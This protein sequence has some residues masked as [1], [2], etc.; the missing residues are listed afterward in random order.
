MSAFYR[1]NTHSGVLL[2]DKPS[3]LSSNQA[4]V[5]AKRALGI[6]KAGHTGSLDPLASGL[7]PLCFGEATKFVAS[8]LLEAD[9]GYHVVAK[10]GETTTTGDSEGDIVQ[11]LPVPL[12]NTADVNTAL[13]RFKGEIEQI[14]PMYSA[15]KHKGQPLYKLARAG[16]EIERAARRIHIYRLELEGIKQNEHQTTVSMIVECSKG[17]Y[18]RSLVEDLGNALGC[19]AHV[20]ALRRLWVG[21]FQQ[22][23]MIALST[24]EEATDN[25]A[26]QYLLPIE[27]AL[28][29]YPQLTLSQSTA[30]Y[31]QHGQAVR[32]GKPGQGYVALMGHDGTFIGVGEYLDDGRVKPKRLI[33]SA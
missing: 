13:N 33:K 10:L 1:N 26:L 17:T 5:R 12:L 15:L 18:I 6:K 9:K 21:H 8:A 7:L 4:L 31:L 25:D 20:I 14:P 22:K 2:L 24:L 30:F 16:K 3:G 19:G 32:V 11:A 29:T 28:S 23:D 27:E